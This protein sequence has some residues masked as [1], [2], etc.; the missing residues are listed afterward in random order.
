[1]PTLKLML[2]T[3]YIQAMLNPTSHSI[4]DSVNPTGGPQRYP[5]LETIKG[6]VFDPLLLLLTC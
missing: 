4:S 2:V 6:A 5:S 3:F 1:M